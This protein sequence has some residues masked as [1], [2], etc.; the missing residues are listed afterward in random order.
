M[1]EKRRI[2]VA[3]PVDGIPE[4][5]MVPYAHARTL[6]SL[7]QEMYADLEILWPDQAYLA[8]PAD[9]VRARSRA[10]RQAQEHGATHI[11]W[12]D[13]DIVPKP[14]FLGAMLAS[15]HD[16][17]GCPYPRKRVY[18][19]QVRMMGGDAEEQAYQYSYHFNDGEAQGATTIQVVNGCV[20]VKRLAMGCMLTTMRAINAMTEK[21]RDEL[22]FTDVVD[23]RHF[24]CVAVFQLML[25]EWIQ[26]NGRPF[27]TLLSEDYSFCQRYNEMAG[28]PGHGLFG[29]IQMLVSHPADHVGQHLFRGSP[30]GLAAAASK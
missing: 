21:Y 4:C 7:K 8:Y 10:I 20:P 3:T 18:W 23:G 2:L 16:F 17:I 26:F 15:G 13:S 29:P 9:L 6:A 5:A 28:E 11:L 24:D 22:G 14:G 30:H 19:Q 12:L 27:R 1:A 25:T